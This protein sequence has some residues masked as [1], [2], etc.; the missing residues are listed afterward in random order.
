MNRNTGQLIFNIK[1]ILLESNITEI[2]LSKK[3]FI[4]QTHLRAVFRRHI[5]VPPKKYMKQV[6][7]HK[8]QTLLR[9]SNKKVGEIARELGYVN[10][11]KFS[12]DFKKKYNMTPSEYRNRHKL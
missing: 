11:S 7:L 5:G 8:G 3:L 9:M 1:R 6:R 4:S 10:V 12:E 2:E